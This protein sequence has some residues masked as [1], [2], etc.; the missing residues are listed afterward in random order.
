MSD[1]ITSFIFGMTVFYCLN[2]LINEKAAVAD[3]YFWKKSTSMDM[4]FHKLYMPLYV[5]MSMHDIKLVYIWLE[6]RWNKEN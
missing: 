4:V 6:G 5:H 3:K 2:H 1:S